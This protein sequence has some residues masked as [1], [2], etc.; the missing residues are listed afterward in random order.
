MDVR[1]IPTCESCAFVQCSSSGLRARAAGVT[2]HAVASQLKVALRQA[3]PSSSF[4]P[5]SRMSY[6][7][8]ATTSGPSTPFNWPSWASPNSEAS[9]HQARPSFLQ[10][11]TARPLRLALYGVGALA[12][13]LVIAGSTGHGPAVRPVR[14]LG[15]YASESL[16][17]W[18]N[19]GGAGWRELP[20]NE[21]LLEPTYVVGSDGNKYPPDVYPAYRNPYKRASAALVSLVRNGEKDSMRDSMRHVEERFN[22]KFG[23]S[24]SFKRSGD[25][26]IGGWGGGDDC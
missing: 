4:P 18:S 7:P 24:S 8:L 25:A 14:K 11:A 6:I 2:Q 9:V 5:P 15:S 22:R 26:E 23:V 19:S 16:E 3:A 13:L 12:T 10:A 1:Y 20:Q 17:G 21:G